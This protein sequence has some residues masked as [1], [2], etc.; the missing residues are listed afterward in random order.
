MNAVLQTRC[1]ISP[2]LIFFIAA[3]A[4]IASGAL[5]A[6][7][8]ETIADL[9]GL[10]GAWIGA[11]LV[12]GA[13]S[14]PELFT[15][16]YAVRDGNVSLALGALFGES[17]ANMLILSI[18]DLTTI[19]HRLLLRVAASQLLLASIAIALTAVIAAG[20][21]AG[22]PLDVL[23]IGWAPLVAMISYVAGMRLLFINRP[24]RLSS[25]EDSSLSARERNRT[26]TRSAIGFLV[27][28][29]IIFVTAQHLAGSAADIAE[30]HQL[31]QGFVGVAL[32]SLIASL[33]ELTVTITSVRRGSYDLAVGNVLGS[34]AFN[35]TIPFV[36]DIVYREG[37]ILSDVDPAVTTS[38]MFSIL[39]LA[40]TLMEILHR[41]ERRIWFIEPDA[42]VRIGIYGFGLFL[43][44]QA[45]T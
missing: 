34:C 17:M 23:G 20:I 43:V 26:L 35:M 29:G 38:A 30:K 40:L 32:L 10:G 8:G 44:Y 33:P 24:A 28:A 37:P 22:Q 27:A 7:S 12:A 15:N 1:V 6:R 31:S 21:V 19:R 13:T 14:L 36:L 3:I 11:I 25:P 18:A 41:A 4:S 9:T 2:E 16:I 45:G 39:L 5:L 42:I